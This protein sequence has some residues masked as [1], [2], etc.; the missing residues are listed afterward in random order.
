MAD[1]TEG[2]LSCEEI[3]GWHGAWLVGCSL[4]S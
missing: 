3:M 1:E 2:P 4:I